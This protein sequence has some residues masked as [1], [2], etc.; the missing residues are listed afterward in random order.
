MA[1]RIRSLELEWL[2]MGNLHNSLG[3]KEAVLKTETL[4]SPI[5]EEK[6]KKG[7]KEVGWISIFK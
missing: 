3:S 5:F 4:L 7:F 1:G 2:G 6:G